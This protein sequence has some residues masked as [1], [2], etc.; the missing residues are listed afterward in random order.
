MTLALHPEERSFAVQD[1][2]VEL[3]RYTFLPHTPQYESP[4]PY[5]HPIRTRAGRL[6]SLFRPHDHV[7]HKGIAWSLPVV[8]E[9]NFWGGRSY[10]HGRGYV[11]LGNDGSQE[12]RGTFHRSVDAAGVLGFGHELEWIT[13]DGRLL[14][15]E[16]RKLTARL[17]D[18]TSWAL[19]FDT[20]LRNVTETAIPIGSPT[21]RGRENAG[22]GGLFWRGPRAFTDG[23]VLTPAGTGTGSEVR[24]QRH[25]WLAFAGRHDEVD[26]ASLVL[27]VDD[28][29]NPRHPPQWFVRSEEFAALNPAPFFSEELVVPPAG[30]VRFRY[31]VGIADTSTAPEAAI[32]RAPVLAER[33]SEL[34]GAPS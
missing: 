4:K 24:G 15:T 27:I 30:S 16:R 21:T 17:L 1:G 3:A 25:E 14:F 23:V 22:Y 10:V 12:H 20:E 31:A 19:T 13:Q 34:L 9:E 33:L 18:E 28:R 6:V 5:L 7:W 32:D 26:A 2:E 29:A 11:D 8:G